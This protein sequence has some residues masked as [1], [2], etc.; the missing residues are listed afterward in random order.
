MKLRDLESGMAEASVSTVLRSEVPRVVLDYLARL[1]PRTSRNYG[2]A[3]GRQFH[4]DFI[5]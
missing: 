5:Q 4:L 3:S 2:F 1:P